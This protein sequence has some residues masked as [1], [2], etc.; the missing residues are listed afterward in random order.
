M[1]KA[2]GTLFKV[3]V[4]TVAKIKSISGPNFERDT[5]DITSME[6]TNGWRE[7]EASDLKDPGEVT[8]EGLAKFDD[9]TGQ[10]TLK[11][12]F[13]SGAEQAMSIVYPTVTG[14]SWAFN[15]IVTALEWGAELEDT[16]SFTC[17]IKVTG[18]PVQGISASTGMSA[19]T[20]SGTNGALS[21]TFAIGKF[22][23]SFTFDTSTSIAVTATAASHTIKVFIDDVYIETVPS[24]SASSAIAF[25]AA[26]SKKIDIV[27]NEAGKTAKTYTVI[28]VRT[29]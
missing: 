27:V 14:G 4:N 2:F 19:L 3:G 13:D 10:I 23:Y 20:I 17:T 28:A 12:L 15:G 6:T 16:I 1:Y 25:S 18:N 9:S 21:P 29:A 11:T 24:G 5:L 7:F 26:Q 22:N 8:I